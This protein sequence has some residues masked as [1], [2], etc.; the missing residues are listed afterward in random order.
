MNQT[1]QTDTTQTTVFE[2]C[3]ADKEQWSVVGEQEMRKCLASYY[4]DVDL[5]IETIKTGQQL[6]TPWAF[7]R[8]CQD[9]STDAD[10]SA[11]IPEPAAEPA[12]E[13]TPTPA[14][15]TIPPQEPSPRPWR[16][17]W[18][19]ESRF[20]Q[21]LVAADGRTVASQVDEPDA[22]FILRAANDHAD[23][24][25]RIANLCDDASAAHASAQEAH[26]F[27]DVQRSE[28]ERLNSV[29]AATLDHLGRFFAAKADCR[30]ETDAVE[31][32]YVGLIFAGVR[33]KLRASSCGDSSPAR[34]ISP[35][36]AAGDSRDGE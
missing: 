11:D 8:V 5:A 6:R 3:Y 2:K 33:G 24:T 16:A 23:A 21:R 9:T 13:P 28:I 4:T 7:F 12:A 29:L 26:E 10:L 25:L 15:E 1:E 14:I 35:S 20:Y 19:S 18:Q 31:R 34:W 17:E 30:F 22:R 32:A 27:M 36:P